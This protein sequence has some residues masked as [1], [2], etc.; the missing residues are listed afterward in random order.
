[1]CVR[2]TTSVIMYVEHLSVSMIC[3]TRLDVTYD[4][5][6]SLPCLVKLQ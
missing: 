6:F 2:V 3:L 5:L 4:M 1:M